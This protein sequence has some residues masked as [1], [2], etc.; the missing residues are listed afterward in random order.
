MHTKLFASLATA[1]ICISAPAAAQ[2]A[3]S[4]TYVNADDSAKWVFRAS[5]GEFIQYKSI[6]GN[7]GV[8]TIYFEYS[9]TGDQLTYRQT[10][11]ELTDHPYAR[12]QKLDKTSTERIEIRADAFV[13]AGTT[14]RRQ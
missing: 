10:K 11:I 13:I 3:L 14:Y 7:P 9:I 1:A 4:G 12:K 5:D 8:I 6:N 2:S